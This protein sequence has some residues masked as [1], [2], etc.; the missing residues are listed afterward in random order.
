MPLF[1][2]FLHLM[3]KGMLCLCTQHSLGEV[4]LCVVPSIVTSV[5]VPGIADT[6]HLGHSSPGR[7]SLPCSK[8]PAQGH[9]GVCLVLCLPQQI[10]NGRENALTRQN[11]G[12]TTLCHGC[13]SHRHSIWLWMYWKA[14]PCHR[15]HPVWRH[16]VA[17]TWP[18]FSSDTW[19]MRGECVYL[20]LLFHLGA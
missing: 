18:I 6:G 14:S 16:R 17:S 9:R 1:W 8:Q 3:H 4:V 15:E 13:P 20:W 19:Q 7:T 5:T 2:H 12:T 10:P 11:N